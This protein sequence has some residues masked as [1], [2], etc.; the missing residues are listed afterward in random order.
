VATVKEHTE[1]LSASFSAT[2]R[3][4]LENRPGAFAEAAAAIAEEGGL[5]DAIDLVWVEEARKVRDV[6][7]LATE[8]TLA[9]AHAI[10]STIDDDH[11]EPDY[12]IPSVFDRNVAPLVAAAVAEV[13]RSS[14]VAR[15][16][17]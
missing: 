9:A 7:A 16:R 17:G 6:P 1:H 10:A 13:A 15:K 2:I 8:M 12:V 5:L 14:G 4:A 11:L 3:L